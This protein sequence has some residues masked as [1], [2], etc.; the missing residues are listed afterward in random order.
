MYRVFAGPDGES[1]IEELDLGKRPELGSLHNVTEL[2]IRQY[3][4]LRNR[5]FH[6]LP[7]RAAVRKE[8]F[9]GRTPEDDH[10]LRVP[11][12]GAVNV[13]SLDERRSEHVDMSVGHGLNPYPHVLS[14]CQIGASFRTHDDDT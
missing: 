4:E 13:A 8:F 3:Q 10:L 12:V 11:V 9:D 5:D 6:P 1:H 14:R 2:G 7:E